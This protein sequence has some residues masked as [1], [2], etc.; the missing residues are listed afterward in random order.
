MYEY[1]AIV[2]AVH[3]GDTITVD[4]DLGWN[5]WRHGEV[6]RLAGLDAPELTTL[7]GTEAHTYLAGLLPPGI[8]AT[9]RTSEDKREKYGR[10]LATVITVTAGNVNDLLITSGHAKPWNGKGPRP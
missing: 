9:V 4:V 1:A 10:M 3:D 2:R 6:L 5:T 7:A 8:T